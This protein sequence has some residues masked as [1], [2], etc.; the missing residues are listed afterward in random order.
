MSDYDV[1]LNA[2]KELR[3]FFVRACVEHVTDQSPASEYNRFWFW[4]NSLLKGDG[5]RICEQ[6]KEGRRGKTKRKDMRER[7]IMKQIQILER[8]TDKNRG[9]CEKERGKRWKQRV[10][11]GIKNKDKSEKE[12]V[13]VRETEA[14]MIEKHKK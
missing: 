6:Q 1:Q 11:F 13:R 3:F 2:E 10:I 12:I 8:Q 5:G 14:K 9:H 4:I 7:E